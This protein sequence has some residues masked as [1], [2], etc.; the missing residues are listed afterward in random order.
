MNTQ[1]ETPR[2]ILIIED[3]KNMVEGIRFN[4]EAR[5][6]TVLAAYDGESG[7]K[8]ADSEKFDLVILDLM[9]PGISGYE[10]CSQLKEKQPKLP[11]M[12]LTAK[13]QES[14]IVTGLDLGADD[15][16]T[17]PFGLLELI[18]RIHALLRRSDFHST[19]PEEYH[20]RHLEID[21]VRY[22][23]KKDGKPLRLSPREFDILR[24]MIERQGELVSRE[25]LLRCVWGYESSPYT[26]TIDAHMAQLR[27]KI[28]HRPGHP[29]LIKTIH[30][31]GYKFLK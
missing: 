1:T 27:K 30:G 7:L 21:F 5:G 22:H 28:E 4:L 29:E 14:D 24:Y 25:E 31:K 3:E 17:K 13:S 15:Y 26:R 18:A 10:V 11:I 19:L 16:M 9:L 20:D 6:F 2:K 8:K 23:A 12:M